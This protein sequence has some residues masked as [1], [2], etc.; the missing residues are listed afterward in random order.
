M[1]TIKI[2]SEKSFGLTFAA[3]FFGIAIYF[4]V[5]K[6]LISFALLSIGIGLVFTSFFI[7]SALKFPNF[8]WFHF[9]KLLSKLATP[10]IL[11]IIFYL[12]VTPL[13][14]LFRIFNRKKITK[15]TWK[16]PNQNEEKVNFKTQF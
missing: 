11:V 15:T 3:I 4:Y 7:P 14:L 5:S 16:Y 8:L 1:K 12:V 2:P 6:N 13:G 9:G 10:A